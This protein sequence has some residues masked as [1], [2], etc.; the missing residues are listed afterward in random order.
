MGR[1]RADRRRLAEW[2]KNALILLL[3]ASALYLLSMT[4]LIRESGLPGL[5]HRDTDQQ[6]GGSVTLTAA[7]R[8]SRMALTTSG[9]RYAL[10]YDQSAVDD[11]FARQGPLLGEALT[12]AGE[13]SSMTESQWRTYLKG[14]SIY[15]DFSGQVP[16]SALG[17]WL[18]QEGVCL[19][20]D[21]AR[22]VL[23]C[24]GGGDQVLLC[25]ESTENGRSFRFSVTALSV[26]LHLEPALR[27]AAEN[28]AQFAFEN[29]ELSALL[30]PYTLITEEPAQQ[31]YAVANPLSGAD[32]AADVLATLDFNGRSHASVNG[33]E[34]Y[35]DGND[36]LL[37]R[38][39]GSVSFTAGDPG[40][41]PVA[42]AGD[43]PTVAEAIEA[44]RALAERTVGAYCGAAQLYLSAVR[45]AG[46]GGWVV[47][48]GYRLN[49]STVWLY[50]DGW[51][52]EVEIAGSDITDFT[53][54]FRSYTAAGEQALLLPLS[55]AAVMLPGLGQTGRELVVRYE[56]SGENAAL[57][58]W[59][60]Q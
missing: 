45:P 6:S 44:A 30:D 41:Y 9:G 34:R 42:H 35:L 27:G 57:P 36:R 13:P 10:Q 12:S 51:A 1:R 25:W 7:A 19:L 47:R 29:A 37:V 54:H 58:G 4:P 60:A 17:T 46:E 20:E 28:G 43:T 2:G 48:F 56:D 5:L 59:V 22:R 21:S 39:G 16:L 32:A 38:T 50:E 31:I 33:G 3:T 40:K 49:G 11:L 52:A 55:R 26:S 53:L 15:F 8:P 24:A 14:E 18:N 23:L